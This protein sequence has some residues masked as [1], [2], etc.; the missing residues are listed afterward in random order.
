MELSQ[1]RINLSDAASIVQE[2]R[3]GMHSPNERLEYLRQMACTALAT[4]IS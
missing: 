3:T 2:V 4:N 1:L